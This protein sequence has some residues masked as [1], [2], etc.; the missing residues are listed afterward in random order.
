MKN[1]KKKMLIASFFSTLII[2]TSFTAVTGSVDNTADS[3]QASPNAL[4]SLTEEEI[5]LIREILD[6]IFSGELEVNEEEI[7]ILEE[8]ACKLDYEIELTDV[9]IRLIRELFSRIYSGEMESTEEEISLLGDILNKIVEAEV[10]LTKNV[11][12]SSTELELGIYTYNNGFKI[13]LTTTQLLILYAIVDSFGFENEEDKAIADDIIDR[14]ITEDDELDLTVLE[15]I[16]NGEYLPLSGPI[17]SIF[18]EF[19]N[20]LYTMALAIIKEYMAN[21]FSHGRS[22][23][24]GVTAGY[25]SN[26]TTRLQ[27]IMGRVNNIINDINN[28]INLIN[29]FLT[30]W[31]N[32][33]LVTLRDF[34]TALGTALGAGKRIL[35]NISLLPFEIQYTAMA[36]VWNVSNFTRWFAPDIFYPDQGYNETHRAYNQPVRIIVEVLNAPGDIMLYCDGKVYYVNKTKPQTTDK[37]VII[38]TTTDED[39]YSFNDHKF[40]VNVKV[41]GEDYNKAEITEHSYSCAKIN[42]T[43]DF[44]GKPIRPYGPIY[45]KALELPPHQYFSYAI[46]PHANGEEKIY[47]QWHFDEWPCNPGDWY[48]ND[49]PGYLDLTCMPHVWLFGGIIFGENHS[50]QV[51]AG[52]TPDGSGWVSPWSDPLYVW[53]SGII[54]IPDFGFGFDLDL[55]LSSSQYTVTQSTSESTIVESTSETTEQSGSQST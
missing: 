40:K 43:F 14:L 18:K 11:E 3:D 7:R 2:M 45:G 47:Y 53:V 52:D 42:M 50:V 1:K 22:G 24:L 41:V 12:F 5:R 44:S 32:P 31:G 29:T 46:N 36:I 26:I 10:E 54:D 8:I 21:Y 16:A 17:R 37:I 38:Y 51:R 34:L 23:W 13:P 28:I 39:E 6:R 19:L 35:E 30:F 27:G 4:I 48:L 25:L 9:E 33:G 49:E 15:E 20:W 55:G